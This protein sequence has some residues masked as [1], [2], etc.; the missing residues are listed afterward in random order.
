MNNTNTTEE[1]KPEVKTVRRGLDAILGDIK[2]N[3]KME[4]LLKTELPKFILN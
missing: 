4:D 1:K 3:V 2:E